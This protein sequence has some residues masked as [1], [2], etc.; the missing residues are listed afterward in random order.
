MAI[1]SLDRNVSSDGEVFKAPHL[2]ISK[3][4]SCWCVDE[5]VSGH[6]LRN[7]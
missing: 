5:T 6:R 7:T 2:P 4:W 3:S 1:T